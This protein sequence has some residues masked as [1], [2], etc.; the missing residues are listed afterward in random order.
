M[1]KTLLQAVFALLCI[2]V[3]AQTLDN[4]FNGNGIV[5]TDFNHYLDAMAVQPDGK[6]L[7][8]TQHWEQGVFLLRYNEDGSI[9][10]S[11]GSGGVAT[12]GMTSDIIPNGKVSLALQ[13][14]GKALVGSCYYVE[15][16][17]MRRLFVLR[18]L[19]DGNL[20][21]SFGEGGMAVNDTI[22]Y[23]F[24]SGC[25][26]PSGEAYAAYDG[27]AIKVDPSGRI[28]QAGT[29]ALECDFGYPQQ[30][31]AIRYLSDG[32]VDTSFHPISGGMVATFSNSEATNC[33]LAGDSFLIL[34]GHG[35]GQGDDSV[36]TVPKMMG[37]Y[38]SGP[39][40][41]V[42]CGVKIADPSV[43][44]F[45]A[46]AMV[47]LD[48]GYF[49]A[50][51]IR[52][53]GRDKFAVAKVRSIFSPS[54]PYLDVDSS[55]GTNGR[56]TIGLSQ[57]YCE[58]HA[59][60]ALQGGKIL[61]G[62]SAETNPI[63]GSDMV[64]V[65]LNGDG[66]PDQSF[67]SGGILRKD[68]DSGTDYLFSLQPT[69]DGKMVAMGSTEKNGELYVVLMRYADGLTGITEGGSLSRAKAYPNPARDE[70]V[71]E[72]LRGTWRIVDAAGS[73]VMQGNAKGQELERIRVS[74]LPAGVYTLRSSK[75]GRETFARFVKR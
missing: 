74:Q 29:R 12:Y 54:F 32:T 13:P 55:F 4:T 56:A 33:Y 49:L 58:L 47:P 5:K 15:N 40:F 31:Y 9:D 3:R 45:R 43:E 59:A 30:F 21:L 44:Y 50:G 53:G 57:T 67:A 35:K 10:Q 34:I 68:H 26:S 17:P 64:M 70:V 14:D 19:Q 2:A 72:G 27:G 1:K 61:L 46:S 51:T 23:A 62:G 37:M 48:S 69:S 73:V 66:S 39:R 22:T 42:A 25:F 16:T 28:V 24:G 65:R 18:F 20:D 75:E 63:V 38:T 52:E 60:L 6:I 71:V 41:D 36:R 7:V 11:F 8:A